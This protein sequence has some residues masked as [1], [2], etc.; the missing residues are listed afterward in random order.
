MTFF[1]STPYAYESK[2]DTELDYQSVTECKI[3]KIIPYGKILLLADSACFRKLSFSGYHCAT[4]MDVQDASILFAFDHLVGIVALGTMGIPY[5]RYCSA[6]LGIPCVAIPDTIDGESL[7]SPNVR[8][9]CG[10]KELDY[11]APV[12]NKIIVDESLLKGQA[13]AYARICSYTL[14]LFDSLFLSKFRGK[15]VSEEVRKCVIACLELPKWYRED[16]KETLFSCDLALASLFVEG[17]SRGTVARLGKQI[18]NDLLATELLLNVYALFFAKGYLRP[19]ACPDYEKRAVAI[20]KAPIVP[21]YETKRLA[22][23]FDYLKE[24]CLLQVQGL[25]EKLPQMKRTYSLLGGIERKIEKKEVLRLIRSL[26]D[27]GE[28]SPLTLMR[29]FGLLE[30]R[31]KKRSR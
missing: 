5:A 6:V 25:L 11:P 27:Y 10:G 17:F 23:T 3:N 31:S 16:C 4:V 22:E 14:S 8:I 18:G 15:E 2:I 7:F 20:G 29:E 21:D 24:A 9:I 1:E 28:F 30:E 12:P 26:P 19:Y 13:E